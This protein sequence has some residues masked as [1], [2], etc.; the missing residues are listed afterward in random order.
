[1]ANLKIVLDEDMVGEITEEGDIITDDINLQKLAAKIKSKK[2]DYMISRRGKND[3]LYF[4][5]LKL[6]KG[7]KGYYSAVADLLLDEGYG[8]KE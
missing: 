2:F 7:D 8:L 1:M 3:G 4:Y 5:C 6:S